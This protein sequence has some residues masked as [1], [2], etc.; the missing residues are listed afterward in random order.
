[1]RKTLATLALS[2][3]AL[4]IGASAAQAHCGEYH[5]PRYSSG[6]S[7]TTTTTYYEPAYTPVCRT[8]RVRLWDPYL[9]RHVVK[10]TRTCR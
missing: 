3:T 8:Q 4:V 9:G 2:V 6:Y 1:M 7:Q 10:V 5:G